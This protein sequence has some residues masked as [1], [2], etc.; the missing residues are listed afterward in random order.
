MDCNGVAHGRGLGELYELGVLRFTF[1]VAFLTPTPEYSVRTFSRTVLLRLSGFDEVQVNA[2]CMYA[3]SS[4]RFSCKFQPVVRDY[5]PTACNTF[6]ING[7]NNWTLIDSLG[8]WLEQMHHV[9]VT[10]AVTRRP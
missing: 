4:S 10:A 8:I 7:G 6:L 5:Y 1:Y 2:V 3:H 9:S